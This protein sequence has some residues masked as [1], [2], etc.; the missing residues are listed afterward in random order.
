MHIFVIT[1]ENLEPFFFLQTIG[2]SCNSVP[3]IMNW[4]KSTFLPETQLLLL[5]NFKTAQY[6]LY[7]NVTISGHVSIDKI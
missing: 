3:H 7:F 2:F 1:Q 4:K 5:L 6:L